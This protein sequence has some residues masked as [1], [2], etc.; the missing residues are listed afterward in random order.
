ME[1]KAG[2]FFDSTY[3][4]NYDH[5]HTATPGTFSRTN[6]EG[7]YTQLYTHLYHKQ[8]VDFIIRSLA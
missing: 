5:I 4:L 8:D 3:G 2:D 1:K 7:F 6:R